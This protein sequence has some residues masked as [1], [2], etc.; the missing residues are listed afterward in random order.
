MGTAFYR[1]LNLT[2]PK[3]GAWMGTTRRWTPLSSL[4]L[5]LMA[6]I[7]IMLGAAPGRVSSAQGSSAIR[8]IVTGDTRGDASGINETILSELAQATLAERASFILVSGDLV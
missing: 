3:R 5:R 4:T 8:F 6:V 2:L 7:L 1:G